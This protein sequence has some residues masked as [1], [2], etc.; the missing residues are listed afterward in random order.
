MEESPPRFPGILEKGNRPVQGLAL[1][2]YACSSLTSTSHPSPRYVGSGD[3]IPYCRHWRPKGMHS[4]QQQLFSLLV[5]LSTH[6]ST[7]TYLV[8]VLVVDPDGIRFRREGPGNDAP[9]AEA[10]FSVLTSYDAQ[11]RDAGRDWCLSFFT[12]RWKLYFFGK[13]KDETRVRLLA[14]RDAPDAVD[15]DKGECGV[16]WYFGT[17]AVLHCLHRC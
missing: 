14:D 3:Q 8:G 7:H 9:L 13:T 11:R 12:V 16:L 10:L 2:V 4:S 15:A 1:F 6:V 5:P 17:C